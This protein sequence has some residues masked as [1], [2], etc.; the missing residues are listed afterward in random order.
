MLHPLL[1]S[2]QGLSKS[3]RVLP[4]RLQAGFRTKLH[5]WDKP[6]QAGKT[7]RLRLKAEMLAVQAL[8]LAL[9]SWYRYSSS[10]Q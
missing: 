7:D 8:Q 4:E 5:A 3:V 10:S 2:L 9:F 1:S 6:P